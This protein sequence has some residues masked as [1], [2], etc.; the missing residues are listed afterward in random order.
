MSSADAP[1]PG[2][3]VMVDIEDGEEH[4]GGGGKAAIERVLVGGEGGDFVAQT[5]STTDN[6]ADA[7]KKVQEQG[8]LST[9]DAA[10]TEPLLGLLGHLGMTRAE[11]RR[12]CRVT[13]HTP[14]EHKDRTYDNF[15]HAS[16]A[17]S[18]SLLHGMSQSPTFS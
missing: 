9:T 16:C 18:P 2:D 6:V 12:S 4:G 1:A 14:C 5:L 7:I 17:D 11:V 10:E 8:A 13:G 15:A 3:S